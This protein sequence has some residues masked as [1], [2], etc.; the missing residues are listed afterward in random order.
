MLGYVL[1]AIFGFAFGILLPHLRNIV[2]DVI[3]MT[4]KQRGV[5]L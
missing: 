2:H 5:A 1:S 3:S 4:S